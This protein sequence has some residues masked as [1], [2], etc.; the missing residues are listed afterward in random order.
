MKLVEHWDQAWRWFSV[1]AAIAGAAL[2][3]SIIAWPGLKDWLPDWLAHVVG[4]LILFSV[5][6]GRLVQQKAPNA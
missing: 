5:I 1:Q 4:L 2:Q 3:G 6:G